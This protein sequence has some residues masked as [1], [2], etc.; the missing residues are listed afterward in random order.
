MTVQ[1]KV[2]IRKGPRGLTIKIPVRKNPYVFVPLLLATVGWIVGLWLLLE[3]LQ[4]ANHRI[5]DYLLWLILLSW[6][7]LGL[8]G[9]AALFW[10]FFGFEQIVLDGEMLTTRKPLILYNRFNIYPVNSISGL[11]L[12][13]EVFRVRRGGEW[14]DEAR[15]VLRFHTPEKEVTVGRGSSAEVLEK[16]LLS[17]ASSGYLSKNQFETVNVSG[18]NAGS[19]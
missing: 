10:I 4:Q 7:A 9:S 12:D 18:S 3:F 2:H 5:I 6:T 19:G 13:K 16:I 11:R 17:M 14:V 15:P 8:A 1:D